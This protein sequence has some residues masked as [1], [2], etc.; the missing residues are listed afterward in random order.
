MMRDKGSCRG[1]QGVKDLQMDHI[2][3]KILGGKTEFDNLQ[4]LCAS[5][6]AKKAANDRKAFWA[7]HLGI[8]FSESSEGVADPLQT[9]SGR[10]PHQAQAQAQEQ[11]QKQAQAHSGSNEKKS[12]SSGKAVDNLAERI[13]EWMHRKTFNTTKP[14]D[15]LQEQLARTIKKHGVEPITQIFEKI[16]NGHDPHPKVFWEQVKIL[17]ENN[18]QS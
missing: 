9:P 14:K 11:A 5:C 4:V 18:A 7:S 16:A 12:T 10:V 17:K 6:N 15:E 8:P 13:C 3:A 1:C 2:L